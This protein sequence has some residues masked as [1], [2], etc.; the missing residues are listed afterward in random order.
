MCVC[1]PH[2]C[3]VQGKASDV[4]GLELDGCEPPCWESNPGPL[5]GQTVLFLKDGF[6]VLGGFGLAGFCLSLRSLRCPAGWPLLKTKVLL[7]AWGSSQAT[8]WATTSGCL[9]F[10]SWPLLGQNN[11]QPSAHAP[12]Y[13]YNVQAKRV[14]F[15]LMISQFTKDPASMAQRELPSNNW[16][17]T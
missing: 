1:G 15:S 10:P 2:E 6:V 7:Q 17:S 12:V 5:Q 9:S 4:L 8:G 3:L 16:E 14:L 11:P 13:R